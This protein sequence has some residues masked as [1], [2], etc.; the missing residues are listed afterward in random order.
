[1][2]SSTFSS[3]DIFDL[4]I[5]QPHEQLGEETPRSRLELRYV[6]PAVPTRGYSSCSVVLQLRPSNASGTIWSRSRPAR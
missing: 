4:G 6:L 5:A 1:M 2:K 3:A